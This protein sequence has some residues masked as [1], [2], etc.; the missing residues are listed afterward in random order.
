M[1][2]FLVFAC[3]SNYQCRFSFFN[4]Y[5]V[6]LFKEFPIYVLCPFFYPLK[7]KLITANIYVRHCPFCILLYFFN[8]S[9]S[10]VSCI[11][12]LSYDLHM[13]T[14]LRT[15]ILSPVY[16]I[17]PPKKCWF[18]LRNLFANICLNIFQPWDQSNIY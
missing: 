4:V 6:F 10:P 12:L 3:I 2:C 17:P 5:V 9:N 14:M 7:N 11:Q 16:H 8:P 13:P 1:C 15:V 18:S